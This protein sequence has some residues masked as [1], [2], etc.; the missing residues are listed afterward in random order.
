MQLHLYK[1]TTF[2]RFGSHL[3]DVFG[4]F[5][6]GLLLNAT[7]L[8]IEPHLL[9]PWYQPLKQAESVQCETR[10][11]S[12]AHFGFAT[13]QLAL[14]ALPPFADCLRVP[15]G[16]RVAT[17]SALN[18]W[19]RDGLVPRGTMRSVLDR[20]R[21]AKPKF[22]TKNAA[23]VHV[24]RGDR[25]PIGRLISPLPLVK[26]MLRLGERRVGASTLLTE[27]LNHEDLD[28]LA[29]QPATVRED[30]EIMLH[31]PLLILV[32]GESAFSGMI[33]LLRTK[34]TVVVGACLDERVRCNVLRPGDERI[35]VPAPPL[36]GDPPPQLWM[37]HAQHQH[38]LALTPEWVPPNGTGGVWRYHWTAAATAFDLAS[39]VERAA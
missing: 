21:F 5:T 22:K 24:R 23:V 37:P 16:F 1:S 32:N 39:A 30:A 36:S 3:T 19:E 29:P 34:P 28:A 35:S 20:M 4:L 33:A 13:P 6:L 10:V 11:P 15:I 9:P 14:Q 8:T 25:A 2:T 27:P 17:P 7:T 12:I 31:A 26:A 18:V 38:P